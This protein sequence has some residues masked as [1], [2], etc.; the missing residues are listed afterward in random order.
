MVSW[1]LCYSRPEKASPAPPAVKWNDIMGILQPIEICANKHMLQFIE[2]Y[3]EK[4]S[5]K[6]TFCKEQHYSRSQNY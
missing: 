4:V 3:E 6:I 2:E 5:D 1:F